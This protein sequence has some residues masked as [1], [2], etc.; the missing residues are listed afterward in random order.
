MATRKGAVFYGR[1][2]MLKHLAK[3][4]RAD[5]YLKKLLAKVV[6]LH[7]TSLEQIKKHLLETI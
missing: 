7:L 4:S 6:A 1:S 3:K 5:F 2:S